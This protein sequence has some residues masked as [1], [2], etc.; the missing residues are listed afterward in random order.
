MRLGTNLLAPR[1]AS[2]TTQAAPDT[3]PP[4]VTLT[5]PI[6]GATV[7]GSVTVSANASDNVGVV[8]VRFLLDGV[9]ITS[10]D[11]SAPYQRVVGDHDGDQRQPYADGAVPGMR[12]AMRRRQRR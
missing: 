6:A 11:T 4:T 8:G 7:N 5:A 9:D 3:T 2:A 1:R 12:R 10:E